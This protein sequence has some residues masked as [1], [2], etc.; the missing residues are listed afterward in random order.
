VN[1]LAEGFDFP[2]L[3][4]LVFARPTLSPVLFLQAIGRVLRI[5]DDKTHGFLL[6]LT[7]NTK[8]FGT[9][10]DNVRI[11]IPKKV[12]KKELEENEN[13]KI[14]P[15]CDALI[16]KSLLICNK[17]G[18]EWKAAD[19]LE[20]NFVPEMSD[21]TFQKI[22]PE[23][24]TVKD[25]TI[26]VHSAKSGKEL[27]FVRFYYGRN[28]F[29][30]EQAT[31]WFCLPDYYSGYPITKAKKWWKILSLSDDLPET[32]DDFMHQSNNILKPMDIL[33]DDNDKYPEIID[34]RWDIIPF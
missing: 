22:E 10:L 18:F 27:C 11:H 8:R 20:A 9:D 4:C 1:I 16:F 19:I 17:C 26:D 34:V 14:C 12:L 3:D 23:W 28:I 21:V 15:G 2:K 6:D 30:K 24:H 7:D 33:I 25:M 5:H 31:I 13:Y 29:K 32:V